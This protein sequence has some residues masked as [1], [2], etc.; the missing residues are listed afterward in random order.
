M[1]VLYSIEKLKKPLN[2]SNIVDNNRT[3]Q[4][5]FKTRYEFECP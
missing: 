3:Y 4:F 2:K 5:F 1:I